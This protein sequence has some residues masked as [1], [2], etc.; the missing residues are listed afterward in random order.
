MQFM[1][2]LACITSNGENWLW[3]FSL[4]SKTHMSELYECV[5]CSFPDS[6]LLNFVDLRYHQFSSTNG[7]LTLK[8]TTG[9]KK[10]QE[11]SSLNFLLPLFGLSVNGN[12]SNECNSNA[13]IYILQ[14]ITWPRTYKEKWR[15]QKA[16]FLLAF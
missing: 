14:S 9:T 12:E 11:N 3:Q 4:H 10:D 5:S 1:C 15:D 6:K 16:N 13:Y 7:S 8:C 2:F